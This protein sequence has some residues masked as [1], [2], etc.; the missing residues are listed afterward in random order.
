MCIGIPVQ[1]IE[2]RG[3]VA[4]CRGRNGDELINMLLVGAQPVGTWVVNFLGSARDVISAEEAAIINSALDGLAAALQGETE[5][6][7]Y[8]PSLPMATSLKFAS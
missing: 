5:L 3:L 7:K 4:L 2:D 8:F 6:D 1:V